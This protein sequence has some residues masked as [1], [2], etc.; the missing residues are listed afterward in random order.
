MRQGSDAPA[1][2]STSPSG[3]AAAGSD[4]KCKN[5]LLCTSAQV[6][7]AAG[8]ACRQSIEQ[9]AVYSPRWTY[10][11][12]EKMFNDSTWLSQEKGTIT[13]FGHEAQFQNAGGLYQDVN[14]E[15]D[16]DPAA[17]AVLDARV[18]GASAK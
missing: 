11:A 16:Y 8:T 7:R 12:P 15:C 18:K 3:P 1:T 9:L 6:V 5:L 10:E 13:F 14:Y 4:A 2:S 17:N